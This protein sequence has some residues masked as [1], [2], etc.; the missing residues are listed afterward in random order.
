MMSYSVTMPSYI[1]ICLVCTYVRS[2][3]R[4]LI[5]HCHPDGYHFSIVMLPLMAITRDDV[6]RLYGMCHDYKYIIGHSLLSYSWIAS[7]YRTHA[8]NFVTLKSYNFICV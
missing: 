7:S 2:E 3:A 6:F 1:N 5:K 8:S 4:G